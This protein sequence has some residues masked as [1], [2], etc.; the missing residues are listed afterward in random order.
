MTEPDV[1]TI[2]RFR[3]G[4][5]VSRGLW[6]YYR[7][8]W[9]L[10]PVSIVALLPPVLYG[11][12]SAYPFW[13]GVWILDL[14][15]FCWLSAGVSYAVVS[16]LRGRN[17]SAVEVLGRSMG[18]V[19]RL[20]LLF[21]ILLIV[22]VG[23]VLLAFIPLIGALIVVGLSAWLYVVYWVVLPVVVVEKSGPLVSLRRSDELTKGSRPQVLGIIA[24]W[25]VILILT[26]IFSDLV[27]FALLD[28]LGHAVFVG[29]S[30]LINTIVFALGASL[31]AVGYHDLRVE[32][33][34]VGAEEIARVFD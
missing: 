11:Y 19:P 5:V 25:F 23:G 13:G 12:W 29:M 28:L 27:L 31:A 34:G 7:S 16:D 1:V 9:T 14:V 3:V 26:G 8:F 10:L 32:K 30:T 24:S 2:P 33:E 15:G 17:A 22:W 18:A 4:A 20:L 21:L 6:F